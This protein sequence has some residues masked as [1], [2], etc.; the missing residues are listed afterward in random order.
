MDS[1]REE[2]RREKKHLVRTQE[3]TKSSKSNKQKGGEVQS[4]NSIAGDL[5]SSAKKKKKLA[6]SFFQSV[7][8]DGKKASLELQQFFP[9]SP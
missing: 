5:C 6:S 7:G 1:E 3:A 4:P 2:G 9:P 8:T